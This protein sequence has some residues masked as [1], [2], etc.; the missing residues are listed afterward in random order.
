MVEK[1]YS[2]YRATKVLEGRT[3]IEL[4]WTKEKWDK[5]LDTGE[6]LGRVER[7]RP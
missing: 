3:E 2:R 1:F 4:S 5:W 6:F 7:R